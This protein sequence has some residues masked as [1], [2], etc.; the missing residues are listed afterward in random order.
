M[1]RTACLRVVAR[2]DS[3]VSVLAAAGSQLDGASVGNGGWARSLRG[4]SRMAL[5]LLPAY[6]ALYALS[7]MGD[8]EGGPAGYV[9]NDQPLRLIGWAVALCAGLIALLALAA[10]HAAS[11]ARHAAAWGLVTGLT[12]AGLMLPFA[13]ISGWTEVGVLPAGV[14]TMLGASLYSVGWLLVGWSVVRSRILSR[15]DGVLLMVA[16]PMIGVIGLLVSPM[17]TVGA[18][19]VLAAGIG[20]VW[21]VKRPTPAAAGP[22]QDG[23]AEP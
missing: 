22:E 14:F 12:G 15:V 20:V 7:T 11:P 10:L 4:F 21:V 8:L 18:L 16:A 2:T 6:G 1:A 19:L 5:W 23:R 17:Q 3:G 9:S 13:T